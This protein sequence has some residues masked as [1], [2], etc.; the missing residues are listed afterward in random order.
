MKELRVP[1]RAL[2]A[3]ALLLDG[4][5][6]AG[7]IFVPASA[8]RHAGATRPEEWINEAGSFFPFLPDEAEVPVILNKRDVLLLTVPA[9]SDREAAVEEGALEQRIVVECGGRRLEGTILID[10]P[11]NHR[12]VLDYLNRPDPFLTLRVGERDHL[13]QK[14]A[15]SRVAESRGD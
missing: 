15:I 11:E 5:T 6:L 2:A 7:R 12:R 4:R 9:E 14:N 10:M 3:E 13:V 1:T 8:S